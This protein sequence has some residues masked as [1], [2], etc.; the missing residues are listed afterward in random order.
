[1]VTVT[2]VHV[3]LHSIRYRFFCL[4]T[5]T[6]NKKQFTY[7]SIYP[8]IHQPIIMKTTRVLSDSLGGTLEGAY[9]PPLAGVEIPQFDLKP[10]KVYHV[11]PPSSLKKCTPGT[12]FLKKVDGDI[13]VITIPEGFDP[14]KATRFKYTHLGDVDKII[15]TTLPMVPGYD[16]V[17][18][19]PIVFG[20]ETL[21]FEDKGYS[22]KP[23]LAKTIAKLTQ[24]AQN[25][26]NS[27]AIEHGCNA[28]LSVQ[29]NV[30]MSH[31]LDGQGCK[32][33]VSCF[34]TPCVIIPSATITTAVIPT[35][36]STEISA[37]VSPLFGEGNTTDD[38]TVYT[39]ATE[40]TGRLPSS[41]GEDVSVV[42]TEESQSPP[43]N[44]VGGPPR[45]QISLLGLGSSHH[46]EHS[47]SDDD[48]DILPDNLHW[49]QQIHDRARM[50]LQTG[51]VPLE[52]I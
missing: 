32:V 1:M 4:P 14:I 34:G 13:A 7:L 30:A 17:H 38:R 52:P 42:T 46:R 41:E 43:K 33:A 27:L 20:C 31:P 6:K 26:V 29:F 40:E 39:A 28:V 51:N 45:R 3:I 21:I 47:Q 9:A 49:S 18:S 50:T 5:L 22:G 24:D 44:I 23:T 35:S 25:Q 37:I 12:Q 10:S 8:S 48:A 36:S 11:K 16:V 15:A 2:T 19:K